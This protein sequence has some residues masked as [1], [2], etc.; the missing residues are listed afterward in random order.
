VRGGTG[1]FTGR[2]AYVWI[3]NQ[4]GNTGVL[5]GTDFNRTNTTI[6]PFNPDPET[7]KPTTITGAPATSYNLELIDPDFKVPQ[8]WRTN[9]GVDQKLPGGWTG[10]LELIYNRDVNGIFYTNEN[11]PAAQTAYAGADTRQRWTN[12]RINNAAGNQVSSAVVLKNQ[13]IG[14]SWNV[15]S[16]LEKR[17]GSGFWL[18]TAYSYGEAKNTIDPGS[19]A[20]GSF[21][22]NPIVS[23]PN[24]A[25]FSFSANSPGHRYFLVTSYSKNLLKIGATS[26]SLFWESRTI[27]NASYIFS[28]DANGDGGSTNDL[29]YVPRD[30]SEMNFA[31]FSSTF[32][33]VTTV[34]TS[35]AQ[36]AAWDAYIAQDSY[37]SSRRGQYAERN[38]TFLPMVHRADFSLSQ[39][40]SINLG[41]RKHSLQFRWDVDNLTNLLNSDWGVSQ[42]LVSN[43]RPLTNPG[44]D[45]QGRLNYRLAVVNGQL[46]STTFEQTSALTDVYRMMF[47]LKYIF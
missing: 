38:A 19:I 22:S 12:N 34:F 11:L 29:I 23:D 8:Q 41:G 16:T 17:F 42:R 31:Q 44:V 47:S 40:I 43:G 1:V 39:D 10:T 37:L 36:A 7:Y 32:Q 6:R 13:N 30:Q 9:V 3:S 35:A 24:N 33:G 45:A 26:V 28:A 46:L 14:R 4:V 15:A 18:K 2:P 21:T 27:G 20:S 25:P 5:T